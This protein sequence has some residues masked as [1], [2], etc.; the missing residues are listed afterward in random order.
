MR[1]SSTI[2]PL[3]QRAIVQNSI[4][5]L[6]PVGGIVFPSAVFIGP[7]MVPLNFAIEQVQSPEQ[8]AL[9][10]EHQDITCQWSVVS[11]KMQLTT[12]H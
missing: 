6:F 9:V 2:C 4:S 12:D 3:S 10:C 11:C 8:A 7:F 5:K 1:F